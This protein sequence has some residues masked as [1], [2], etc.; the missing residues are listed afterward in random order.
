[1]ITAHGR[2][3]DLALAMEH[4]IRDIRPG[5]S[6]GSGFRTAVGHRRHLA[7][8]PE[9][10]ED[11]H[12]LTVQGIVARGMVER[13]AMAFQTQVTLQQVGRDIHD[14][15]PEELV[16]L[17]GAKA[18]ETGS[19]SDDTGIEIEMREH[20]PDLAEKD[21][22]PQQDAR[23]QIPLGVDVRREAAAQEWGRHHNPGARLQEQMDRSHGNA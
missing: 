13:I 9:V 7:K 23:V 16:G 22:V 18:F 14:A 12:T 8:A 17:H 1:M 19:A 10:P 5:K 6:Q 3:K 15:A 4:G 21:G 20:V 2:S 11:A